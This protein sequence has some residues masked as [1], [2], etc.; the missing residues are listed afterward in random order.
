MRLPFPVPAD[1][2]RQHISDRQLADIEYISVPVRRN[3][4]STLFYAEPMRDAV[5]AAFERIRPYV[6]ET[7]LEK[8]SDLADGQS[9]YLKLEHLQF[10]G[11]FKFRG[12]S[13]KI[14]LLTR[15]Q[16]AAGCDRGIQRQ[17]RNGGR[18]GCFGAR[19]RGGGLCLL[20]GVDGEGAAHRSIGRAHPIG[21]RR[22]AVG[23]NR[24]AACGGRVRQDLHLA[25]QR[26]GSGSGPRHHW[27]R[28]GEATPRAGRGFR[29]SGRRRADRRDRRISEEQCRRPPRSW[30]AG[31]RMRR[32][33]WN[34]CWR[35]A[36]ST[37]R[38]GRRFPKAPRAGW[39]R[40]R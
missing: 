37:C 15:E 38:S 12:A 4:H 34:A 35:G 22:S 20:A 30:D 32:S 7:P 26:F 2:Q 5:E 8:S 39:S 13:N 18:G 27:R 24:G 28:T 10:T 9:V 16:A 25:V 23:G 31:P 21:G 3:L 33:C 14:A 6:R 17:S 29:V 1:W 19:H 40:A 36:S 11:S